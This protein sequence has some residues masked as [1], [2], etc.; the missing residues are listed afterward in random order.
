MKKWPRPFDLLSDVEF[1]VAEVPKDRR[2]LDQP[3]E[4]HGH[5]IRVQVKPDSALLLALT[6]NFS[7]FP[8]VAFDEPVEL[9]LALWMP[10]IEITGEKEPGKRLILEDEVHM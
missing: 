10:S 6:Y 1:T 7:N 5:G 8:Q 3:Q 9:C 2:W 4:H